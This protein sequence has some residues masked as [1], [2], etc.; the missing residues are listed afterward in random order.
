[1]EAGSVERWMSYV[2]FGR[3]HTRA[4]VQYG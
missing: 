2:D 4:S 1:V 3:N